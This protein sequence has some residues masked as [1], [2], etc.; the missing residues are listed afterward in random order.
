[1]K[2]EMTSCLYC[3]VPSSSCTFIQ[4]YC[5]F[6]KSNL[7][8]YTCLIHHWQTG[9]LNV[10]L[11]AWC[12]AY[13][14]HVGTSSPTKADFR[15]YTVEENTHVEEIS[16]KFLEIMRYFLEL[17]EYFPSGELFSNTLGNMP[18]SGEYYVRYCWWTKL[19][20]LYL[21]SVNIILKYRRNFAHCERYYG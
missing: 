14:S 11:A 13:M 7:L 21:Q 12:T 18:Y 1:M 9:K 20:R 5:T 2:Y 17:S 6:I 8:T 16:R 15:G 4:L 3:T 19:F 10:L